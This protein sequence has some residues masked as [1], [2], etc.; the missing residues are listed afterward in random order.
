MHDPEF[1]AECDKINLEI[2]FVSGEEVEAL[3]KRLYALP[4]S[5]VSEARKI[6]AAK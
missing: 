3:V 6:V 2:S 4:E 1:V 5:V